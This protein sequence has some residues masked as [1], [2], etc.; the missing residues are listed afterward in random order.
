[1]RTLLAFVAGASA[2][3]ALSAF[4]SNRD[5]SVPDE[6]PRDSSSPITVT[7]GTTHQ[8]GISGF[9]YTP[10]TLT[11][12]PGDSVS[13]TASGVHP[14]RTDDDIFSC[15]ANCTQTFNTVGEF[16][17]YCNN[18]GGP[19]GQGMSGIITVQ[20][21]VAVMALSVSSIGAQVA[22]GANAVQAFDIHNTGGATLDWT[23]DTSSGDCTNP[24]AVAWLGADPVSGSIL[25]GAQASVDATFDA[26]ALAPGQYD[27]NL[28]LHS[29]DAAHD[30]VT[31]PVQ[32]T[33]TA[34][35]TIFQ[36]GFD[37]VTR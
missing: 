21:P 36:N 29:N 30:P 14:L 26:S 18:H 37:G 31:L 11:I 22:S 9:T 27:A 20:A 32:L 2:L 5:L 19:G 35:D 17:F 10:N 23:A 1:M 3:A 33:V 12:A 16:R 24:V 13:F 28:C 6:T 25:A 34:G 4:A 15:D 8:V 7:G